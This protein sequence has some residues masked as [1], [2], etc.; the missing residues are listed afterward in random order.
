[1]TPYSR[2]RGLDPVILAA[3]LRGSWGPVGPRGPLTGDRWR[4]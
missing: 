2:G 3:A 4:R 1:V